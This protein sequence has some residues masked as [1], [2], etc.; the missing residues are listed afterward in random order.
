MP[1]VTISRQFG[2]GGS[3]V[4]QLVAAELQAE[5]VDKKLVDEVAARLRLK[6]SDVEAESERP[7]KLFDRVIRSFSSLEPGIGAA[8][9][10]PYPDDPFFDPRAE[11]IRL[12]EQTIKEGAATGNVVIVGR[13]AGFVLRDRPE[14]FRVFLRAPE[15][16]RVAILMTRFD[17][18]EALAKRKIHET[19]ANRAAYTKQ[20]YGHDWTDPDEYDL[21]VNTGRVDYPTAADMILHGVR[22]RS[23]SAASVT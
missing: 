22:Q 12:T 2:A 18:N 4:A 23:K 6:P 8:W 9:T 17:W 19:D 1:V 5:I 16:V 15:A 14:V 21:I 10:P 11:I 3:S 13:G 20:L 7:R